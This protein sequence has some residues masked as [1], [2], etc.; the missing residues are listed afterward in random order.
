VNSTIKYSTRKITTGTPE[1]TMGRQGKR[2]C[3]KKE[4][5]RILENNII[6]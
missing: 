6:G 3:G 4:T 2:K 1:I 5:K